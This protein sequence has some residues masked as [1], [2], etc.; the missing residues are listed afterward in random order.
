MLRNKVK[1][2]LVLLASAVFTVIIVAGIM[3]DKTEAQTKRDVIYVD[4]NNTVVR[5]MS[6]KHYVLLA[7]RYEGLDMIHDPA[8]PADK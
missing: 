2:V 3:S 8:C 4:G 6:G 1:W 5:F 7:Y